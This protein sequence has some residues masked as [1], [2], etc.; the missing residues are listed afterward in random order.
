MQTPTKIAV[1]GATGRVG[2]HVVEVLKERG[3]DVVAMSRATGVDVITAE[4]L[5]DA[6]AALHKKKPVLNL[7]IE[8]NRLENDADKL[9]RN[10]IAELF[11]NEKDPEAANR[12]GDELGQMVFGG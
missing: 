2:R 9:E 7:C 5:A 3:L 1:A 11:R 8:I 12:L 10:L 4:G 6:L